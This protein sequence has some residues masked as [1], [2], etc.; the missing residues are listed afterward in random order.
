V[1]KGGSA[2]LPIQIFLIYI[3][4]QW[5][6]QYFADGSGYLAQRVSTAKNDAHAEAGSLWFCVAN[7]ALRTWPWILIGLVALVLYP[8]GAAGSTASARAIAADR[9]MAYPVLMA[10]LLPSGLLG[11]LF[12][13][14]LAAFM[15]TVDTQI[16]WGSSYLVNDLYLRFLRP[17][18]TERERVFVSRVTVVLLASAAVIVAGQISSIEKAWKFF[19]ALGAGLGLP[20]MLRWIWWRVNAWTEIAGMIVA[21]ALAFVLYGFFP[22]LR[23]EYIIAIVAAAG[24]VSSLIATFVTPPVPREHLEKFVDKVGPP[25][26][27]RDFAGRASRGKMRWLAYAWFAGNAAVFGLTF[28]IGYLL[29]GQPLSGIL[30]IV[31]GTAG[32]W[33]TLAATG[34]ARATL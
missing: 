28:G 29:L 34:R 27:W 3:G 16:N 31:C 23:D 2:W 15:S 33:L 21:T 4:V 13:S 25:G 9:E 14:L 7:Y 30:M 6:A 17:N 5:W 20:S 19:I 18:A 11:L 32:I 8:L 12:V 10:T 24:V 1:P 26:W 22:G